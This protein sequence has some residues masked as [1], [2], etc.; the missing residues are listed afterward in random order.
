MTHWLIQNGYIAVFVL[1]ALGII[2]LPVPE[3][4]L[5]IFSG[6]LIAS[7]T[8]P[9]FP[10]Y[11]AAIGGSICG[12]TVSYFLG[13]TAGNYLI[14]KYGYWIGITEVKI[15]LAHD[16]FARVG[17]WALFIGYFIMGVRH[18]T[19]YVAGTTLLR[20]QTF[21]LFAYSGAII[22]ATTFLSIG[23]I[24]SDKLEKL[25][26]LI[27]YN[28]LILLFICFLLLF[29]GWRVFKMLRAS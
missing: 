28:H 16:W 3:E 8:F 1:L 9:L 19:G 15:K 6:Y 22:W 20:F 5:L 10:T 23:Y 27:N 2:C 12:I 17:K 11:I 18:F 25:V 7:K 21:A 13:F 24:F 26:G 4:T 14:T 29:I